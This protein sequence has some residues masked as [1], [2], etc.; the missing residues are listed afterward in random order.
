MIYNYNYIFKNIVICPGKLLY[1]N[2]YNYYMAKKQPP[3]KITVKNPKIGTKY[4]FRF[5]G[6][7]YYG[8]I[9]EMCEG[10]SKTTGIKYYLIT[11]DFENNRTRYPIAI[12]EMGTTE[13]Q[14][15]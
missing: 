15:K 7:V 11:A 10:L 1:L 4:Y 9:L 8:P 14:L 13:K 6:S 5:A 2:E 12:N 3:R